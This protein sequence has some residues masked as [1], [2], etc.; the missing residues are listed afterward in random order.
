VDVHGRVANSHPSLAV[1]TFDMF[2]D[3]APGNLKNRPMGGNGTGCSR[4][5]RRMPHAWT[6]CSKLQWLPWKCSSRCSIAMRNA[7]TWSSWS[8]RARG[9]KDSIGNGQLGESIDGPL[10]S[11]IDCFADSPMHHH[12]NGSG[13]VSIETLVSFI[14]ICSNDDAL[15]NKSALV[16]LFADC[17]VLRPLGHKH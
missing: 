16:I 8:N 12:L 17:I 4:P 15:A 2:I 11:G 14:G 5:L 13:P 6:Y 9:R 3:R 10:K 7:K 1:D